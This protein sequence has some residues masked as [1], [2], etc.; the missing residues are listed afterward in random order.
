MEKRKGVCVRELSVLLIFSTS[1]KVHCPEFDCPTVECP[2]QKMSFLNHYNCTM[3]SGI[4]RYLIKLKIGTHKFEGYTN[5]K[6]KTANFEITM[7]T[8]KQK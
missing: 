4:L 5:L 2:K 1:L 6:T 8:L 7:F 3:R